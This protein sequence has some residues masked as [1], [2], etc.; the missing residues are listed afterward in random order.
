MNIETS[1]L[2]TVQTIAF[3]NNTVQNPTP[4]VW[5]CASPLAYDKAL[6]RL[7]DMPWITILQAGPSHVEEYPK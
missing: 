1:S 7:K 4:C 3:L 2:C 5:V 6:A